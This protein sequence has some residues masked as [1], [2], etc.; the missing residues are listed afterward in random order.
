LAFSPDGKALHSGGQDCTVRTWDVTAEPQDSELVISAAHVFMTK[1]TPV[2]DIGC[3]RQGL[4]HAAGPFTVSY[5]GASGFL[6][7]RDLDDVVAAKQG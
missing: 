3:T 2:Y 1:N 7:S 5:I 4:V 6:V